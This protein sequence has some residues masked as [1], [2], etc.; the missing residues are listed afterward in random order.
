MVSELMAEGA[1][2]ET[3]VW[4]Y[5]GNQPRMIKHSNTHSLKNLIFK[6]ENQFFFTRE[7][8]VNALGLPTA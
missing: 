1:G 8:L 3:Q 6:R 5:D 4:Y 7:R 2:V